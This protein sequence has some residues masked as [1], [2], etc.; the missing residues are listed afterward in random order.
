MRKDKGFLGVSILIALII[1]L[2]VFGI[3][4]YTVKS[5]NTPPKDI[6]EDNFPQVNQNTNVSNNS[7]TTPIVSTTL[8]TPYISAQSSWPP[9]IQNPSTTYSCDVGKGN[10]DM[11]ERTIQKVI[12]GKTYC[13]YSNSDGAA[14]S[15]YYSYTYTTAGSSSVDI[16]TTSFTLRYVNCGVYSDPQMT[17]CK[18]A[19][20]GFNLDTIVDSLM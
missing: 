15:I 13:I 18:T 11:D 4:Y 7:I 6:V 2:A 17:Q 1:V 12:N 20:S 8:P 10:S 16:K 9:V 3:A 19:Q 14:G 5:S